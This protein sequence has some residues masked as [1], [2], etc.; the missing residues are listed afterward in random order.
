MRY[1]AAIAGLVGMVVLWGG[2]R[3][4]SAGPP[5]TQAASDDL[6]FLEH[7]LV[8]ATDALGGE[9]TFSKGVLAIKLVRS[10]LWVQADM[11]DIP[12]E[13]GIASDF[14]FFRCSCGKDRVVGQFALADYEVNDVIDVLRSGQIDVV[15]VSSMFTGDKPR[16][17]A[18]R[19]QGEGKA[20]DL[21]KTLKAALGWVGEARSARQPIS[22]EKP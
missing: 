15:S 12:A 21:A 5:A 1:G 22:G 3:V 14:Y 8:Q 19:F 10:D 18:L 9:S 17:M 13:A 20:A 6:R 2:A 11:G 16:M 7:D 4:W